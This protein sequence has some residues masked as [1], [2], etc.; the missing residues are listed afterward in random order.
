MTVFETNIHLI[1]YLI[2]GNDFAAL[3]LQISNS[4]KFQH[5]AALK[6]KRAEIKKNEVVGRKGT[7]KSSD[8]NSTPPPPP[9]SQSKQSLWVQAT[10]EEGAVYYYNR[11]TRYFG[12]ITINEVFIVTFFFIYQ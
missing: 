4:E 2:Y 10:T 5:L 8:A 7:Q 11:E 12:Y 6:A 3:I 1:S 9:P